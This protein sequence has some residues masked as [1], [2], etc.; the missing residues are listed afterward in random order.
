M[1][2]SREGASTKVVKVGAALALGAG[3]L[4]MNLYKFWSDKILINNVAG[5]GY[6]YYK[7]C[8]AKGPLTRVA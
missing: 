6:V 4:G 8:P 5:L 7:R 2:T 3:A 1:S